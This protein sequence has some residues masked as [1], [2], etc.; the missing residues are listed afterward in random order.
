M[1]RRILV[2]ERDKSFLSKEMKQSLADGTWHN[3]S[4][5]SFL[6]H[7]YTTR[8]PEGL[9]QDNKEGQKGRGFTLNGVLKEKSN[10]FPVLSKDNLGD[11]S[12]SCSV[13][14]DSLQPHG[15]QETRLPCSLLSPGVC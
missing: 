11:T 1:G 13:V 14:S 10:Y 9:S 6:S 2:E 5:Y 15:L 12:F 8:A 3:G 7:G 4:S